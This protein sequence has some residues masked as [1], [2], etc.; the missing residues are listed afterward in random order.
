MSLYGLATKVAPGW[1]AEDE[2]YARLREPYGY[3]NAVGVTAAMGD[4]ALPVARHA[5][6]AACCRRRSPT[7]CSGC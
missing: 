7:R 6:G 3:W 5:A 1:L 4:P 2:I